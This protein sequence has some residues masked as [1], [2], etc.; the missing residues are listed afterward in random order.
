MLQPCIQLSWH[1][2]IIIFFLW[3]ITCARLRPD[4][5]PRGYQTK[6]ASRFARSWRAGPAMVRWTKLDAWQHTLSKN[7]SYL[8]QFRRAVFITKKPEWRP[9]WWG[10]RLQE[11][12][13]NIWAKKLRHFLWNKM[14]QNRTLMTFLPMVVQSWPHFAA[15]FCFHTFDI[16]YNHIL[17]SAFS[18]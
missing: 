11:E 13:R 12:E 6:D 3:V 10:Q 4:T 14:R 16:I 18:Q 7:Q 5:C 1:V 15:A 17:K 9:W 8:N 2:K